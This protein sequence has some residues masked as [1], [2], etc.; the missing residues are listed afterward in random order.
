MMVQLSGWVFGLLADTHKEKTTFPM[1][2]M[3]SSEL[4]SKWVSGAEPS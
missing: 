1:S 4:N 2:F 3:I